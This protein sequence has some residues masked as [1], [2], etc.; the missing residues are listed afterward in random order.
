MIDRWYEIVCT[1]CHV[2]GEQMPL[3]SSAWAVVK[4]DGWT[5]AAIAG[6]VNH[7]H[8]CPDC[9]KIKS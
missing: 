5:R 6:S 8:W 9:S 2:R 4:R 7:R 3:P 1:R